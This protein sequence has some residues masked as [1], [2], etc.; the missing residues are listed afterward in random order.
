MTAAGTFRTAV[1]A[2]DLAAVT[3]A[4]DPGIECRSPVMVRPYRGRDAV[5]ALIAVLFEVLED[6]R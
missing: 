3:R 4:L 5:T 2:K 1:E 6:F